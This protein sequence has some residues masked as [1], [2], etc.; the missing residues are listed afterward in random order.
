MPMNERRRFMRHLQPFWS[1]HRHRQ[2]P[3]SARHL[4]QLRADSRLLVKAGRVQKMA[5]TD[6]RIKV[7]WQPRGVEDCES[8]QVD[9]VINALGPDYM[10]ERSTDPLT[11][12]LLR[13]GMISADALKLGL[14]TGPYGAC[15]DRRGQVSE[16]LFY[17]GP[18]LRADHWEI[19]GA[20][21]LMQW[22]RELAEH[23]MA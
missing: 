16:R 4:G 5:Q 12:S 20:A 2:P 21:E 6:G 7:W 14:R 18:M 15:V 13:A 19:T 23:L 9:Y 11:R 10:L 8:L 17:L 22:A 1:V 3:Q